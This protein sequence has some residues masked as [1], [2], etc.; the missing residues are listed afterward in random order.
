MPDLDFT[1]RSFAKTKLPNLRALAGAFQKEKNMLK[2][3]SD[4]ATLEWAVDECLQRRGI[5]LPA[6]EVDE[7]L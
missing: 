3:A 2:K 6:Q 1:T 5:T 4:K 7:T